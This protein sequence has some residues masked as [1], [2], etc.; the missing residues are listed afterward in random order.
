[1]SEAF[2][3]LHQFYHLAGDNFHMLNS[4]AVV[5]LPKKVGVVAINDYRPISLIHSIA[6]LISKVLFLRLASVIHTLISPAQS[7]FLRTK[8][9]HDSFL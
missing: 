8:C 5:L 3:A 7:A 1:M 2:T 9:I 4:A 6:K